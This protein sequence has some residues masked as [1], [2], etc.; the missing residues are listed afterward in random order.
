MAAGQIA[1]YGL[2]AL[3]MRWPHPLLRL[4]RPFGFLI[5][6]NL[7]ILDAW[8][9]VASGRTVVLWTPSQR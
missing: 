4:W 8:Y 6:A 5:M 9:R 7:S 1:M 2:A 3:S